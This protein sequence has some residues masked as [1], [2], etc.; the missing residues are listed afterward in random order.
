ML[1]NWLL[2]QT[3]RTTAPVD[4][5][6]LALVHTP[7]AGV[8]GDWGRGGVCPVPNVM[9]TGTVLLLDPPT[10]GRLTAANAASR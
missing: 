2:L 5:L 10:A 8:T 7:D 9:F 3:T 1:T 4:S 6:K